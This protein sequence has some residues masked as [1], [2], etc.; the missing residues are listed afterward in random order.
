MNGMS[1]T[2]RKECNE[3]SIKFLLIL[4]GIKNWAFEGKRG[5]CAPS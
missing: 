4:G 5:T 3:C 1:T 2:N